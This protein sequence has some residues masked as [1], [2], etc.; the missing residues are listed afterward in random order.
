MNYIV[1]SYINSLVNLLEELN[2]PILGKGGNV[3]QDRLP[4]LEGRKGRNLW[5]HISAGMKAGLDAYKAD[6]KAAL[7]AARAVYGKNKDLLTDQEAN[8]KLEKAGAVVPQFISKGLTL[9]P[10][11]EADIG[12]DLCPCA[13]NECRDACLFRTGKGALDDTYNSR[14]NR[15]K[16]MAEH[17]DHFAVL[18]HHEITKAKEKAAQSNKKLVI[19]PNM[20]SDIVWEKIH[21]QLFNEHPDVQFYDYTKIAARTRKQQPANYH[22]TFSSTGVEGKG[23]NWKDAAHHLNNGGIVAMV[24]DIKRGHDLPKQIVDHGTGKSYRVIDGDIHD[25]RHI[26]KIFNGIDDK[27]GVVAGLRFKSAGIKRDEFMEKAGNFVVPVEG[28]TAHVNKTKLQESI[29]SYV[30]WIHRKNRV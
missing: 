18:F 15:T 8:P 19:R 9:S 28:D 16:F 13:T 25:H 11:N 1:E 26:D 14:I 12:V 6:P 21:P 30:Y 7:K 24:F 10:S 5:A 23:A 27:E 2:L 20:V 22:L 29:D 3:P 17:P 4:S